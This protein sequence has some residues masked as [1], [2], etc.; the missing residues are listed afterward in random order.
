MAFQTESRGDGGTRD[1]VLT[2]TGLGNHPAFTHVFS[3]KRLA[4]RVIHLVCARMIQVL[5]LEQDSGSSNLIRQPRRL[6]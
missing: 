2:S 4:N 5:A 6:I 3:Q 1:T